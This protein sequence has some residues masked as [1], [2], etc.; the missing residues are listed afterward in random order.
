MDNL[1]K[2]LNEFELSGED[3]FG[4]AEIAGRTANKNSDWKDFLRQASEELPE[5]ILE[6]AAECYT[7]VCNDRD[8]LKIARIDYSRGISKLD[9]LG[10]VAS[11][12]HTR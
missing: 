11:Y 5:G 6:R 12:L 1:A 8:F 9:F 7:E 3:Y 2:F 10:A 4:I